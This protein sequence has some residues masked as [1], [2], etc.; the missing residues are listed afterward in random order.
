MG[1]LGFPEL[2]LIFVIALIVFGPKRLP[3]VGRSIGKAMGEFKKA[4][5]EMRMTLE[6]EV[7]LEELKKIAD[8]TRSLTGNATAP[9][10]NV[11]SGT[12][13]GATSGTFSENADVVAP[14]SVV[15]PANS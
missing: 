13:S 4:T 9:L 12:A 6:E 11:A 2:M 15:P 5:N 10:N 8:D 1:S 7:R 3:E 14:P